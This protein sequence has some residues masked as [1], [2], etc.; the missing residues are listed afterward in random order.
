MSLFSTKDDPYSTGTFRKPQSLTNM[1][2]RLFI[3]TVFP[4]GFAAFIV[5]GLI[6][7][8]DLSEAP[9]IAFLEHY[10]HGAPIEIY[11]RNDDVVCT[12]NPVK[13]KGSVPLSQI[14]DDMIQA[15]LAVEDR[16]FYEHRGVS[17]LGIA[18]AVL[19]NVQAGKMVQ[20]GSTITQQLVKNLFFEGEKR[21]GVRKVS[22]AIIAF[23]IEQRYTKDQILKTYL[24][25]IYFGNGA[26]GVEQAAAAYFG[27][28]AFLLNIP[29]SAFLAGLI[30]SPSYYGDPKNRIEALK[31]QKQVLGL[32][33]ENGY[34]TE[35]QYN[36]A[37]TTPL[38]FERARD[39]YD[40]E[41]FH[42][43]PYFISYVLELMKGIDP[44]SVNSSQAR[45]GLRIY[46]TLDQPA[47]KLAEQALS[48]GIARAPRGIEEGALVSISAFDGSIKALVGGAGDYW[49]NQWNC[50]TNPHTAGSVFKPFVYL[51][52]FRKG[53][54]NPSSTIED[55]KLTIPQIGGVTYSPKNFDNKFLG[56]ITVRE[57][58]T[59][60]RNVCAVKVARQ[61]GMESIVET[62]K[63]A[64]IKSE[65]SPNLSL[66]LGSSAVSPLELACAY[67]TFAR[68]GLFIEPWAIRKI[69]SLDGRA[70]KKFEP[71]QSR[72]L[73]PHP[74]AMLTS[75]LKDVV[76]EGTGTAARLPNRPVAGKTGTADHSTDLWFVGFTPDLVTAVWAGTR[77]HSPVRG[78]HVTGGT[79]A[80][81]IFREYNLGYYKAHPGPPGTLLSAAPD[82]GKPDA[83]LSFSAS[84]A[85]ST[86]LSAQ[87]AGSPAQSA[88][89]SA[90]R[91]RRV[92][93]RPSM[94]AL[95]EYYRRY[96]AQRA[97]NP[98]GGYISR[99]KKGVTE[100]TW[101]R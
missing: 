82:S 65:M 38:R 63:L 86:D 46:T 78:R 34:L 55:T 72:T 58:L 17:P 95:N 53:L 32:M 44:Q 39:I 60:S 4:L 1:V 35:E 20:G 10:H 70:L 77:D 8:Y 69:T 90:P 89:K 50:A 41:P 31:R 88:S 36:F 56:K 66:A 9:D 43:Y 84:P 26:Y 52:A 67:S 42:K 85:S 24:N 5:F 61:I 62:A 80:A 15:V 33:V 100:Y 49:K 54:L 25:E 57:A 94:K 13:S 27:K 23:T 29:E 91:K 14:S 97:S 93:S 11:D 51:T 101:T 71:A 68:G 30:K 40:K 18:R 79:V 98:K 45:R 96:Y 99:S 92:A 2:S 64:G 28:T 6:V 7:L 75:V 73:E 37:M 16:Q 21:T 12:I 81:T 76:E 83:A 3:Y 48:H 74:I 59:Q 19:A 47:Q 22:E 87:P